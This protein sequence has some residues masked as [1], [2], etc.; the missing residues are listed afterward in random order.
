MTDQLDLDAIQARANAATPGPWFPHEDWPG[1]VFAESEFNAHVARVTG[2]NPEANEQFI[3]HA[4]EDVPAL[5]AE[6]RRL[7]ART[8]TESE[9]NRAW[10]AIEGAAGQEGADPGTVLNAV[11]RALGINPPA[12]ETHIVSDDSDDPEHTDDCPGCEAA[13][14]VR[15]DAV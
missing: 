15:S 4:R 5:V 11:L 13:P 1:R 6:V 2:S 14:A 12:E 7:R 3:A 9:H 8:L 10:H